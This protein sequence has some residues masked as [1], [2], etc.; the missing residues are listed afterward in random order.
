MQLCLDLP[1]PALPVPDVVEHY[2]V[3]L[4]DFDP[5]VAAPTVADVLRNLAPCIRLST[6][7]SHIPMLRPGFGVLCDPLD[8][9]EYTPTGSVLAA[10][11]AGMFLSMSERPGRWS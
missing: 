11:R 4:A 8:A 7:G 5:P 1:E 2:G 10:H 6:T 9:P 3:T